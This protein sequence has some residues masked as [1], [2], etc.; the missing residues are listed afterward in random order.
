MANQAL[1]GLLA[2]GQQGYGTSNRG[3]DQYYANAAQT[4][5]NSP[6]S[7]AMGM[8]GAGFGAANNMLGGIGSAMGS[9]FRD[10]TGRIDDVRGDIREGAGDARGDVQGLYDDSI[11]EWMDG[12]FGP[13]GVTPRPNQLGNLQEQ[14]KV[15][16][17]LGWTYDVRTGDWVSPNGRNRRSGVAMLR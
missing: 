7:Q 10:T 14:A 8:L 15:L 1:A 17:A 6:Q 9:G 3:M 4:L 16:Q 12:N 13:S 11:G 5:Q 2:L